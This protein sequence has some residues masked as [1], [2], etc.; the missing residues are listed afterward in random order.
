MT[1]SDTRNGATPWNRAPK[2]L[3]VIT[4]S[5]GFLGRSLVDRLAGHCDIVG[6]DFALPPN[7]VP[8]LEAVRV[9]LTSEDS[10]KAALARIR[11]AHGVRIASVI[12]LAGYYDLSGDPSPKYDEV[13]VRGTERLLRELRGF[14]VEQF[15]FVSTMLVHAP[16]VPSRPID[17]EAPLK[18]K[19]PYPESKLR[20][21]E[22]ITRQHGGLPVVILRPAGIYDEMCHAAFLARQIADIYEHQFES[23]LYPG[24]PA[25]GQPYLHREDFAEAVTRLIERRSSLPSELTLVLTEP[26]TMGYEELQREIG[27]A[28]HGEEWEI[29]RIP[30][31][32]A[33]AGQWIQ[34]DVLDLDPFFQ[35]WMI[36]QANDHYEFDISRTRAALDWE[37][38]RRLRQTLPVMLASLKADPPRWYAANKLNSAK[39]AA[40]DSVIDRAAP[41]AEQLAEAAIP[42]VDEELR[43]RHRHTLW[44]HLTNGA[45][46][47]WLIASPFTIGLFDPV[48][49]GATPPAAGHELPAAAVRNMRLGLSEIASGGAILLLSMIALARPRSWAQ[50]GVAA[51]GLWLLLA[52]LV[53]WTTSAAAYAADTLLGMLV[54]VFAVMVPNQPGIS[55]K[56]LASSADIPLGWSYSPSSYVQR[57]PIVALAFVGLFVSR[58][59]AAYQMG[60]VGSVWDPFFPG[61]ADTANGTEA[62]ITSAVSKAFPIA[63]AGFGAMAYALDILTGAIDDRRRWRTSPWLVLI[64]GILIIPLGVVSVGFIIIQ[65][66]VIGALCTLCLFQAAVTVVLIPYSIDEVLATVQ[67]LFQSR[68]AGRSFWKTSLHGGP[69]LQEKRDRSGDLGSLGAVARDFVNGGVSYPW[70]LTASVGIGACLLAAPLL[71]VSS[72]PLAH[73]DHI[74][75]CLVIVIAVTALAEV[76]RPVRF[77]NITLGLWVA[78]SPFVLTGAEMSAAAIFDIV[79]GLGLVLLSLPRG[80]LSGQHYGSWDR[81]IV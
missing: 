7:P 18:P 38:K 72:P 36:D 57:V 53:F 35:P 44:A 32:L 68:R 23:Y 67:F 63:D 24:D 73:S 37:P 49:A 81:M 15:V 76:A 31:A 64:F 55:R 33:K 2:P 17:E 40:A 62:V 79:A 43:T 41:R 16:T 58:Y 39:V 30:K 34:E 21:E 11:A 59:L 77:L 46:G 3:V 61:T 9:D 29:R 45:I 65:P 60:H 52:P 6:L 14:S 26:E 71:S 4:G 47:L 27:C 66:T 51:V 48:T 56:A 80:K 75:G 74:A 20:A 78:A 22:V 8:S 70:T 10:V 54:I 13:T 50:W 42:R 5:S 12:H 19:T 25:N 1:E 69:A 28:L